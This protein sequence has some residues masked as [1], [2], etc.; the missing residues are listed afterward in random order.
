QLSEIDTV[1][2]G[3]IKAVWATIPN[4]WEKYAVHIIEPVLNLLPDRG[5]LIDVCKLPLGT[6][7][8]T[9]V[10]VKWS[11]GIIAQFQTTGKLPIPLS[12]KIL[13]VKGHQELKFQDSF[14]AIKSAL[15]NFIDI[16][17][18]QKENIPR[19]LTQEMITILEYGRNA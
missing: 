12:I 14:Y 1:M 13:G 17:N 6:G 2:I 8:L 10:Q 9:G 19:A 18:G 15:N 7:E 5:K 16:V 11:S 3:D 4:G